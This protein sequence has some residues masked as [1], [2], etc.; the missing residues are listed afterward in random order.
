MGLPSGNWF[1]N[2]KERK[3]LLQTLQEQF[4]I[5]ALPAGV[6]VQNAAG[7]VALLSRAIDEIPFER[8]RVDSLG[9]YLGAWQAEGFRL[10]IEGSQLFAPMAKRNVVVL[11]DAQRRAWLKG[12]DIPWEA[13]E[14]HYVIVRHG[15]DV[16]G[17]GKIRQP[18]AGKDE[19][20]II[21]NYVPKARRLVVVN[22]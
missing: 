12:E 16:L 15:D 8:L 13:D 5:D 4:G 11:G 14:N 10:S 22:E 21:L 2:S 20:T 3:Q 7:K 9:L 6:F 18:R 1:L 17:S 19:T